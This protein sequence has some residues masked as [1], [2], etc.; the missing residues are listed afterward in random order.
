MEK[1]DATFIKKILGDPDGDAMIAS[2]YVDVN[3]NNLRIQHARSMLALPEEEVLQFKVLLKKGINSKFGAQAFEIAP[4]R[5]VLDELR[6][7]GLKDKDKLQAVCEEISNCYKSDENYGILFISGAYDLREGETYKYA[8]VLIHP[9]CLSKPGIIYD[10]PNNSF[11]G[12]KKEHLLGAPVHAFLYPSFDG[13]H[14][15]MSHAMYFAK[16]KNAVPASSGLTGYLFGADVSWTEDVQKQA[17][18]KMLADAYGGSVPWDSMQSVL[19]HIEEARAEQDGG[20]D[21]KFSAQELAKI[22]LDSG[23]LPESSRQAVQEGAAQM[24][25]RQFHAQCLVTDKVDIQS[26]SA[27]IKVSLSEVGRIQKRTIDG[28]EYYLLPASF[29]QVGTVNVK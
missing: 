17:F 18:E 24:H 5:N 6:G 9:C 28:R 1:K 7:D 15:D 19:S 22:I 2:C 16:T 11:T 21:V 10:Y 8:I 12:Q 4:K 29:S 14:T 27:V 25:G 23:D 3:N 26:D 20:D 13:M